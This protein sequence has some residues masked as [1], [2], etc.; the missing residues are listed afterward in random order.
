MP[1]QAVTLEPMVQGEHS[2][3]AIRLPERIG[4]A[5]KQQITTFYVFRI[6]AQGTGPLANISE[7]FGGCV[8]HLIYELLYYF[9]CRKQPIICEFRGVRMLSEQIYFAV[10]KVRSWCL[11]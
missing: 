1:P 4:Y 7:K 11:P 10:E 3:A 5:H 6:S 2:V 8:K 9:N